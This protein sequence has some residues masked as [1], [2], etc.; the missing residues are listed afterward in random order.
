MITDEQKDFTYEIKQIVH[1]RCEGYGK[2]YYWEVVFT[3]NKEHWWSRTKTLRAK[4]CSPR[5]V[6]YYTH[7]QCIVFH[8]DERHKAYDLA[9][10]FDSWS[11]IEAHNAKAQA[12]ADAKKEIEYQREVES[13]Y[14]GERGKPSKKKRRG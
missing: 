2:F 3:K 7:T 1:H 6:W 12:E 4:E 9:E 14:R 10:G 13:Y 5:S 11:A 8:S